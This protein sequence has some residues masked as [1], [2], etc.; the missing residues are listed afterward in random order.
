MFFRRCLR[1]RRAFVADKTDD[2]EHSQRQRRPQQENQSIADAF[3]Q[4]YAERRRDRLPKRIGR[5]VKAHAGASML[6][7]QKPGDP[8]RHTD[9]AA[10]HAEPVDNARQHHHRRCRRKHIASAADQHQRRADRREMRAAEPVGKIA[11]KGTTE[12]RHRVKRRADDPHKHSAG[13]E[14]F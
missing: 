12:Q 7:W 13:A 3:V 5:T 4:K 10:G 11:N 9:R 6:A 8:R 2:D 14:A 1:M